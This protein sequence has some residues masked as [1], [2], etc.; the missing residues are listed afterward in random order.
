MSLE[1]PEKIRNLQ[2]KLYCK[3]KAEP[4]FRFYILYDKICRE[5]VLWHAYALARANA[6]APGVDG[7][8]FEQIDASGVEAWLAGLREDLVTKTYRADPVRRATIPKPGGGERPLGIPTI[9]D[10]VVQTAV[11][12][13]LEP[14]FEADFEDNAYGY[15]PRRSAVD[16]VKETHRLIRRGYTDE[17][18]ADLSKYFDSIPHSDLLKSVARRIVDRHVLHLIKMWLQAPVEER[19]G[20]GTRRMSAGKT[21]KR[22]TPHV[23][24][25]RERI[26]SSSR[27]RSSNRDPK[28]GFYFNAFF[29]WQ[30]QPLRQEKSWKGGGLCNLKPFEAIQRVRPPPGR[31]AARQPEASLAWAAATA[32]VKRRQRMLKPCVSL[33]IMYPLRPS[34]WVGRGR[35][36][37][38]RQRRGLAGSAGVLEQGKGMGRIARKPE[39]SRSRPRAQQAGSRN[40]G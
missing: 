28:C 12:I 7:T 25:G 36:R 26:V 19:D 3:A 6:G 31:G 10:R 2:R 32:L 21:S 30:N 9:R 18:D 29:F 20:D 5:D 39:R 16:A 11:K 17:V 24:G 4:A 33:D 34:V 22:G 27:S 37:Q 15:R 40:T 8:T 23:G 1:T 14:I 38:G 35:R 13:V